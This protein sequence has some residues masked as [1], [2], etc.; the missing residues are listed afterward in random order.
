MN[1]YFEY[2][3]IVVSKLACWASRLPDNYDF[4][5]YWYNL[6]LSP[7]KYGIDDEDYDNTTSFWLTRWRID[8]EKTY[9]PIT[10]E[11]FC[12]EERE[13]FAMYSQYL[14]YEL[15]TPSRV[16]AEYYGKDMFAWLMDRYPKYHCIGTN[17]YMQYFV[18]E[19]G[20]PPGVEKPFRVVNC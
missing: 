14:V 17:L 8:F 1:L 7:I 12:E 4:L 20:C 10:G 13:W 9:T 11:S 2:D 16:I 5:D 18:E 19:W 6:F 15:Q 3:F